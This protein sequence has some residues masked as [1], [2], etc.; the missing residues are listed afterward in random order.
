M[1]ALQGAREPMASL[2]HIAWGARARAPF[3]KMQALPQA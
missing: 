1:G 2:L 3:E